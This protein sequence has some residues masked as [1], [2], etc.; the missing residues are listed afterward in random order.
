M[1]LWRVVGFD[2][3]FKD[4]LAYLVGCVTCGDYVEG[5]LV[6]R[7]E[8]D[9][10]DVSEKIIDLISVSRFRR[11]I[12]C[13]LLSGITFAGFNVA[14]L[15][16]IFESLNIPIIVVLERYPDFDRIERALRNLNGFERRMEC[17][18][19][20]GDVEVIDGVLVQRKGCDESF[21]RRILKLTVRRG[22][23]PE[24]LR[25]AHLV[26]SAIIHRESRRR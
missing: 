17:I 22:K 20:A 1:K 26:A 7:I 10:F 19:R 5:F 14:D 4:D 15:D 12:R 23:I 21:V 8:V 18:R 24:P 13:V 6:D 3:C 16:Y 25:I 2:D 11:Q 9:G